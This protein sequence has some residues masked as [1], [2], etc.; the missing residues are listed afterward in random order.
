MLMIETA[1]RGTVSQ[2]SIGSQAYIC[3]ATSMGKGPS[4]R[5]LPYAP[6]PRLP[7]AGRPTARPPRSPPTLRGPSGLKNYFSYLYLCFLYLVYPA[8]PFG[9]L[10]LRALPLSPA[11]LPGVLASLRCL[12]CLRLVPP[13][14]LASPCPRLTF[15]LCSAPLGCCCRC[16]RRPRRPDGV[17]RRVFGGGCGTFC[18][19]WWV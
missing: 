10:A 12:I 6:P 7:D 16:P 18:S 3:A 5:T 13:S 8:L 19:R 4:L 15:A 9:V 11:L 1:A 17:G 2:R 14:R